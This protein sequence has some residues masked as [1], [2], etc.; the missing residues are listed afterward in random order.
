MGKGGMTWRVVLAVVGRVERDRRFGPKY[1]LS[2]YI[3]LYGWEDRGV[4]LPFTP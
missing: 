3:P 4:V 2:Q 1:E